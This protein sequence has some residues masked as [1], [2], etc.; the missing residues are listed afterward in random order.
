MRDPETQRDKVRKQV[1]PRQKVKLYN[2]IS[3]PASYYLCH[4]LPIIIKSLNP[5]PTEGDEITQRCEYQEVGMIGA[6]LKN[7]FHSNDDN[8]VKGQGAK[9]LGNGKHSRLDMS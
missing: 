9:Y 6:L 5:T 3:K 2:L 4:V 1:Y 7:D 8:T